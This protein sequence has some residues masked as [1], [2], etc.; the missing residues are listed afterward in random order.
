[1]K[2]ITDFLLRL[3]EKN[4]AELH[5]GCFRYSL[6]NFILVVNFSTVLHVL[7][8]ILRVF[9]GSSERVSKN[10]TGTRAPQAVVAALKS[11]VP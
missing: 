11:C 10:W 3:S 2:L 4:V 8:T 7:Q 5:I 6:L 1:M 9:S